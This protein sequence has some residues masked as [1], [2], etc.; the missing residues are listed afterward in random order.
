[1]NTLT[2][3]QI[4]RSAPSVFATKPWGDVSD[5]YRFFP[6]SDIIQKMF[7]NGYQC[8]AAGQAK[9]RIPGKAEFTR[10]VLRFRH[11]DFSQQQGGNVPELVLMNS[12]DRSSAYRFMLG[13]FRIACANGM[14]VCTSMINEVSVRHM[15]QENMIDEVLEGSF[16]V[17]KQAPK[18]IERIN[19]FQNVILAP[20]EQ[21]VFA[22]AALEM[23]G[24]TLD[25]PLPQ[26]LTSRRVEDNGDDAGNRDLWKT[27]NVVQE[28]MIRGGSYGKSANTNRW[29]R[30]RAVKSVNE[31]TKLNRALWTLAEEMKA[32]KDA[33]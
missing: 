11:N 6:T 30:L 27:L 26:L 23:R 29:R 22:K 33:A 12:H 15:G 20:E 4:H 3:D 1:M 31:D 5:K 10:H 18:M 19:G 7:D 16:E 28:K 8:T 13:C 24:T 21:E 25:V 32:I 2:L 9:T 14:V 17:I